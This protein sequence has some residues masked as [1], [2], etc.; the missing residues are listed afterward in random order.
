MTKHVSIQRQRLRR[1]G[2]LI[3]AARVSWRRGRA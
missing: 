2:R 1:P 3:P